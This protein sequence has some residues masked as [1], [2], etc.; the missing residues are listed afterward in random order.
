VDE[1]H[2][3]FAHVGDGVAVHTWFAPDG[4]L[5]YRGRPHSFPV[6]AAMEYRAVAV[7]GPP[8][9][10]SSSFFVLAVCKR[11]HVSHGVA[12]RRHERKERTDAGNTRARGGVGDR[13]GPRCED[14]GACGE[15][16]AA[17]REDHGVAPGAGAQSSPGASVARAARSRT[18]TCNGGER[19]AVSAGSAQAGA[20]DALR[21]A[22]WRGASAR[23]KVGLDFLSRRLRRRLGPRGIRA[24]GSWPLAGAGVTEGRR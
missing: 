18:R 9:R 11:W 23:R 15:G 13:T 16:A 24:V 20:H 4:V 8:W 1:S 5:G 10:G 14:L 17:Q 21:S 19:P 6:G 3:R 2:A 22:A 7:W 12:V